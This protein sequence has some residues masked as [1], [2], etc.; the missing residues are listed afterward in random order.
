M[1]SCYEPVDPATPVPSDQKELSQEDWI[2]LIALAHADEKQA[3]DVYASH[4]LSTNGQVY[5]SDL[6]Q[7]S[8]YPEDYHL[9]LDKDLGAATPATEVIT[10]IYVTRSDLPAFMREVG[11]DFAATALR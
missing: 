2:S 9:A 10:E 11:A 4:Y 7:L 1:L 5:W 6:H 3:F 8:Y